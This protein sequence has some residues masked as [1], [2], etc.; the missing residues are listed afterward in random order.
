MGAEVFRLLRT[1]LRDVNID[2]DV[3]AVVVT[4]AAPGDGK[5]TVALNLA[6]AATNDGLS[7]ALG[8]DRPAPTDTVQAAG[9]HEQRWT[10]KHQVKMTKVGR[11]PV[12]LPE[13]KRRVYSKGFEAQLRRETALS[14]KQS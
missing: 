12:T 6:E 5:T 1:H 10:L 14:D 8:R 3:C 11:R 4:S 13:N 2:R 7:S 9:N